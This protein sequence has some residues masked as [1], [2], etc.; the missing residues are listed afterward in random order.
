MLRAKTLIKFL[1]TAL[2]MLSLSSNAYCDD[3]R[4]GSDDNHSDDSSS[5]PPSSGSSIALGK[6]LKI[7]LGNDRTGPKFVLERKQKVKKGT[8]KEDSLDAKLKIPV[9]SLSLGVAD[10]NAATSADVVLLLKRSNSNYASCTL[11]FDAVKRTRYG[12]RAEYRLDL[13]LKLKN[14]SIQS[15]F[16]KGACDTDLTTDGVQSDFPN[17]I[18]GDQYS[19]S[20]NDIEVFSGS[21]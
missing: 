20:V 13:E 14:G 9:P 5:S 3:R 10:S 2:I 17:I 18:S 15:K 1:S 4:R 16:K 12:L 11:D 7:T 6:N 19:I 21:I 8:A